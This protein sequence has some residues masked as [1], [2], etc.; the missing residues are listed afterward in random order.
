MAYEVTVDEY[1]VISIS[2]A[3]KYVAEDTIPKV[4][5][6]FQVGK[7]TTVIPTLYYDK[8]KK[9]LSPVFNVVIKVEM[10]QVKDVIWY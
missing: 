9:K 7:N 8:S 1:S 10:G 5:F 4:N 3:Y 6:L 2:G